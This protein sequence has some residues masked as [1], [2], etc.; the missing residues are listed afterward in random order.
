MKRQILV[1]FLHQ[2]KRS[3]IISTTIPWNVCVQ[4]SSNQSQA[5]YICCMLSSGV[6]LLIKNVQPHTAPLTLSK[7]VRNSHHKAP[8]L[9]PCEFHILDVPKRLQRVVVLFNRRGKS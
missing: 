6:I 4:Q 7:R 2:V 1:E 5:A 8:D 3:M 9:S